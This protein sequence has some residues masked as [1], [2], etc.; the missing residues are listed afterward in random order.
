MPW[1]AAMVSPAALHSAEATPRF[2]T[3]TASS[4]GMQLVVTLA[5]ARWALETAWAELESRSVLMAAEMAASAR[6]WC[7]RPPGEL[8]IL[9]QPSSDDGTTGLGRRE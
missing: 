7:I 2:V 4:S 1:L 6:A 8:P 3:T 5:Q 9:T